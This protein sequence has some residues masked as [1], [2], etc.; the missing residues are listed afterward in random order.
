MPALADIA[1]MLAELDPTADKVKFTAHLTAVEAWVK[2][3]RAAVAA[4]QPVPPQPMLAGVGEPLGSRKN[5]EGYPTTLYN[6]MIHALVG[7]GMRGAI[8]YQGESNHY[9][10]ALYTEKMKALI[11]GWRAIWGVGDFPFN[12]VQIAPFEYGNE[13]PGVIPRFWVAQQATLAAVPNT[14]MVITTDIG[15]IKD[16]HPK[17]KQEVGRRL[18]LI[19]LH[20]TYGKNAIVH[21]GP[22]FAAAKPEGA[23][24][25]V[26]FTS[27]DGLKTRDGK[28]PDWFE[29]IGEDSE[30]TTADAKI[31]GM[32][33]VVS[34]P[35]VKSPVAVRFAW[36][37]LAEPNLVNGAGLPAPA[38]SSGGIPYVDQ[39]TKVDEAKGWQLVYEADLGRLASA[40]TYTTDNSAKIGA[41]DRIGYFVELQ[42][43]GRGVQ[44][45]WTAMDAFTTD[46]K[47]IGIPALAAN[48]TFQQAV[49]N[50]TVASNVKELT[51]GAIGA[52]QIEFWPNNYAMVNATNVPGASNEI[53]DFG[54]Q[55]GEPKDGYG[56]MQVHNIAAK[57]TVFAI[58]H[59]VAGAGA[60]LG[61]GNSE[62]NTRDW[63][64]TA[65]AGSY[66]SKKLRVLVRLKK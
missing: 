36:S 53:F 38:F 17:N 41:F 30:W 27:A 16:I 25:R 47:K 45:V 63:T 5:P 42:K 39:L 40:I 48:A 44:Y 55:I 19:A 32:A 24:M 22:T 50:L 8:W 10:G 4:G 60:D 49:A 34:S 59:W 54:D 58:N 52:G 1:K 37:K 2:Q 57:Q 11:N 6:G 3:A 26:S 7:Y 31:D 46:A 13:D 56:S 15:N 35:S 12:F 20:N 21:E 43:E 65:N 29:V 66:V 64:F 18:A 14:G 33:V 62:G 61:F 9:E 28:A 51:T 23:A